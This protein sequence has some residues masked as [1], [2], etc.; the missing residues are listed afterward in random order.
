M[1]T[2]QKTWLWISLIMFAM[3]EILWN[4]IV[5]FMYS[6]FMPTINGSTQIWRESFLLNYRFDFLYKIILLVQ[7]IGIVTFTINWARTKN[8]SQSRLTYWVV[9]ILSILLSL[10]TLFIVYLAYAISHISFP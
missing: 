5:N 2:K 4:P 9:L 7:L 3:P 1:E 6:L 8:N 10:L